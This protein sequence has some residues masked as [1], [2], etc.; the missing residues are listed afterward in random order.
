MP[1]SA[2]KIGKY[3]A[4]EV[5]G[6]GN[7][8][9]VYRGYDPF[10]DQEVAI[11]VSHE[12]L[13]AMN[14]PGTLTRKLFFN[15]AQAA[16]ALIHPNIVRVL[17][18]GEHDGSPY[19]VM[20]Y[21]G[22]GKTLDEFCRGNELLPAK[23]VGEI[24]YQ[25]ARALDYSHYHGVIHRDVKPSNILMTE[26]GRAKITDF[27]IAQ[28]N[29]LDETQI[30]GILG[31]PSYMSPEQVRQEDLN[32]QT[33]VYSLGIVMY[34]LLTGE[35]PFRAANVAG[36][37]YRIVNEPVPVPILDYDAPEAIHDI[38]A[39]ALAKDRRDRYH[40]AGEMAEALFEAFDNI[41]DTDEGISEERKLEYLRRLEFFSNFTR[42]QLRE[43]LA[44]GTWN[45]HAPGATIILEGSMDLA[46]YIIVAGHVAVRK[47]HEVLC[48]LLAG[49]CFGE[50][51]YLAKTERTASII[52][53]EPVL[54]LA[55]NA[56]AIKRTSTACQLKFNEA[57]I[58]TL[59]G[60]LTM[61]SE[62]LVHAAK[63][64]Q[65]NAAVA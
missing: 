21:V 27:G 25:C 12:K 36:L 11:K 9:V 24:V 45:S 37:M 20:D 60:R 7:M 16:G 31:S 30:I 43:I 34:E 33:D 44:N 64:P 5:V 40:S 61:T 47:D 39:K 48:R 26:Q 62:A 52:A 29:T 23:R 35:P 10:S 41:S 18:A 4:L 28:R 3:Y 38:L 55:L 49:N 2:K 58:R 42:E 32:P 57:F 17:D 65:R 53:G 50:M 46:F 1:D 56:N 22:E 14:F 51:G 15:E 19:L 8:A 54:L 59:I 13:K 63:R 6:T